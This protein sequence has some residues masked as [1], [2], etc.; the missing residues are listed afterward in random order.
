MLYTLN[1]VGMLI[2]LEAHTGRMLLHRPVGVDAGVAW[3]GGAGA[4][5]AVARNT[6]Y[7]PCDAAMGR[8][9]GAGPGVLVAYRAGGP[10]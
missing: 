2:A 6:V 9:P 4:G 1:N 5:V 8:L 3:R 10:R 7:A